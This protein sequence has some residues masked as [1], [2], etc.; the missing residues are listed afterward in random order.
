ML[1]PHPRRSHLLVLIPLVLLVLFGLPSLIDYVELHIGKHRADGRETFSYGVQRDW[2]GRRWVGGPHPYKQRPSYERI[3]QTEKAL[4]QHNLSLPYPEG[5]NGKYVIFR[6]QVRALGWNNVFNEMSVVACS[7]FHVLVFSTEYLLNRLLSHHVAY[8]AGR[9]YIFQDYEWKSELY[10]W[11]IPANPPPRNPLSTLIAGPT[12]GGPFEAGD[13]APRAVREDW[14][15]VVCG[16]KSDIE[17]IDSNIGK[18]PVF[19]SDGQTIADHWVKLLQNS[20][21]RCVEVIPSRKDSHPQTFDL[22]CVSSATHL[23]R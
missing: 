20:P 1:L 8:R 3:I 4:P 5:K 17:R 16:K 23:I 15:T 19:W 10:P 18:G 7:Q 22:W 12:V 21:K 11:R 14:W 9:S 6:N 2:R 13:P